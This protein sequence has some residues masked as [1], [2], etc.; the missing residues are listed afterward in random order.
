MA[1]RCFFSVNSHLSGFKLE[2]GPN[3]ES[4]PCLLNAIISLRLSILHKRSMPHS[5]ADYMKMYL[6]KK[7]Q[8]K[9]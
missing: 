4:V 2:P 7:R 1:L 8:N 6:H 5:V 3:H 9:Q